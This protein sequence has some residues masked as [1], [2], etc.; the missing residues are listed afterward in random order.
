MKSTADIFSTNLKV[1]SSEVATIPLVKWIWQAYFRTSLIPLLLV[2]VALIVIYFSSNALSTREN[3]QTVRQMAEHELSQMAVRE[4]NSISQQFNGVAQATDF[5]SKEAE[6]VMVR[7]E[8]TVRDAPNRFAYSAEGA[9]HTIRDNGGSAL[10]YSG[11]K[12]VGAKERDKAMRSAGLDASF[13]GIQKTFPLIVQVYY[14]THDSLNRIYPYFD[15]VSQY[16]S[17]MDIPSFNFYYEADA[18]HNPSRGVKWTKVYVDPAGQ[19]WMTSCIA[20]VY[21]GDFL[22]GVVG[23]DVTVSTVVSEVLN[24]NIPWNG[25]GL[26]VS[27][28]GTIIALS[29]AGEADWEEPGFNTHTYD[30]SIKQDTIKPEQSNL[31]KRTRNLQLAEQIRDQS[32]VAPLAWTDFPLS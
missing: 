29:S 10:F 23:T 9:Y 20:P 32:E 11:F 16:A 1:P 6:R 2:E 28:E 7:A 14:N 31:F 22:E 12:P 18:Q 24:L 21:R 13:K 30:G 3:I 19:G 8:S 4:A 5:L 27:R 15:V 25:Y 26:L 17:H